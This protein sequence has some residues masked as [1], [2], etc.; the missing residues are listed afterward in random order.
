MSQ[1]VRSGVD[2]YKSMGGGGGGGLLVCAVY[3]P[4]Q[5]GLYIFLT[6]I[7]YTIIFQIY[8]RYTNF[9]AIPPSIT[10]W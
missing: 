4:T 7:P 2:F 10:F 9:S 1:K 3:F 6:F 5:S 8:L